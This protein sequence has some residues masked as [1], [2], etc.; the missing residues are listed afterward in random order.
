MK[1]ALNDLMP[2]YAEIWLLVLAPA[3]LIVDLFLRE[4]HREWTYLLTVAA[5]LGCAFWTMAT[6]QLTGMRPTYAFSGMFV[7]DTVGHVLK[8][9]TYLSVAASLAHSATSM[10]PR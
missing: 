6:W 8:L 3:V 5:L 4:R 7:A 1:F 10:A 2:A 9:L